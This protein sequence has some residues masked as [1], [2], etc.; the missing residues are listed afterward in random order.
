M[1]VV[2][3]ALKNFSSAELAEHQEKN[4]T[5]LYWRQFLEVFKISLGKTIFSKQTLLILVLTLLPLIFLIIGSVGNTE[6]KNISNARQVFG[7]IYS[8]FIL[9][10]VI[11]LGS[12]IFFTTVF[13][14]EILER[15]VHYY[16]LAP[17]RRDIIVFAKYAACILISLILFSTSTIVCYLLI[18]LASGAARLAADIGTGIAV[19]QLA[20]YLTMTFL[21]CI[22]YGSLFMA[23]GLV[24][25]NPL[26]PILLLAGWEVINPFLPAGLKYLSVL[27]Y[28]TSRMP[29]ILT[30][31]GFAIITVEMPVWASFL[32]VFSIAAVALYVSVL[33]LKKM[34]VKYLE[35]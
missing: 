29:V 3:T 2:S 17:I 33:V 11:F 20:S 6:F 24:F 32:G 15:S 27:Y 22:G 9:G 18:Y 25:R 1:T 12:A 21:A 4:S 23:I 35:D 30:E 28:V 8:V 34:E 14:G 26:L 16:L 5:T 10:A 31:G 19:T 7:Y 13:R